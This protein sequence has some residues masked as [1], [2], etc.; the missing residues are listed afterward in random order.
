MDI[1]GWGCD[2]CV[3]LLACAAFLEVIEAVVL[4]DTLSGFLVVFRHGVERAL[5]NCYFRMR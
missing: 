5:N 1:L 3:V 2:L 4:V